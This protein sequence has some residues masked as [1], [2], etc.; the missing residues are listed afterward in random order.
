MR[1]ISYPQTVYRK[2]QTH[3][4]NPPRSAPQ[5]KSSLSPR[6]APPSFPHPP[7][8]TPC[9]PLNLTTLIHQLPWFPS[10]FKGTWCNG[11]TSVLVRKSQT[12]PNTAP[13][14]PCRQSYSETADFCH[15]VSSATTLEKLFVDAHQV[16]RMRVRVSLCPNYFFVD[17]WA[18]GGA[19][20]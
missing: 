10:H 7:S 15:Q 20:K 1:T 5:S 17:F 13:I 4:P 9:S 16:Q 18:W 2:L 8:P 3:V 12:V 14:D 11:N 19:G 6:P